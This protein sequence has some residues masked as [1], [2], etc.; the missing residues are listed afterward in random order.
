MSLPEFD[1]EELAPSSLIAAVYVLHL[2]D[3]R[4][5]KCEHHSYGAFPVCVRV[6]YRGFDNTAVMEMGLPVLYSCNEVCPLERAV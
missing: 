2:S 6:L 3:K 1:A 4:K 5:F